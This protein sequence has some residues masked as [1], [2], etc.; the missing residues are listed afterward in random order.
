MNRE[1]AREERR[2][3][4]A[5]VAEQLRKVL[6]EVAGNSKDKRLAKD[7][8]NIFTDEVLHG[9]A[10]EGVDG[11]ISQRID[12]LALSHVRRCPHCGTQTIP[13]GAQP[14]PYS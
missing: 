13:M 14:R 10:R 1:Q 5:S 7:L 3:I 4:I 2:S 9:F 11:A 12:E 6:L 8:A